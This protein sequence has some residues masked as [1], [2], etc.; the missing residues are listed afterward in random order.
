MLNGGCR[1]QISIEKHLIFLIIFFII[2]RKSVFRYN[3]LGFRYKENNGN[4]SLQTNFRD[5]GGLS[6]SIYFNM[7]SLDVFCACD[8]GY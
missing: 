8:P 1:L 2:F 7:K 3:S 4:R 5:I 6:S